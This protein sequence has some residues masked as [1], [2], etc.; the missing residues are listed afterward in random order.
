MKKVLAAI[1][2]LVMVLSML[3]AGMIVSS[4]LTS[5]DYTYTVANSEAT[6]T[7]YNGSGG[8]VTIPDSLGGTTVTTIDKSAFER[9][10]GLTNLTIPDSIKTIGNR[11]FGFCSNLTTVSIGIGVSAIGTYAF[12]HCPKL[13]QLTVKSAN[14][15]FYSEENVVFNKTKTILVVCAGGKEGNY[16]IPSTVNAIGESAFDSCTKLTAI[17]IPDGVTTIGIAAFSQ[18]SGLTVV[19]I[20]DS[21]TSI[22]TQAFILCTGIVNLDIGEGLTVINDS[23]FHACSNLV[24]LTI[25]SH[26]TDIGSGAFLGC[27]ALTVLELPNSLINIGSCSF[28][29]CD[30]LTE[31]TIPNNVTTVGYAAFYYCSELT[32]VTFGEHVAN[33]KGIAFAGC[34]KLVSACFTGNAPEL[35]N[36]VFID[37]PS[38]FIINY[39][40]G[41]TDFT[42][43]WYGYPTAIPGYSTIIFNTD[44]GTGGISSPM[45]PG[46]ALVAP[47]VTKAG[48][49]FTGWTPALPANV[50]YIHTTYT[51]LWSTYSVSFDAQGG[52]VSPATITVKNGSAY[53]ALPT[54]IKTGFVFLGWYTNPGGTGNKIISTT[55]VTITAPQTL[56]AYWIPVMTSTV[57]FDAQGGS[58]SPATKEVTSG[59]IYGTLPIPIKTDKTFGG[60]FTNVN[61]TG[62]NIYSTTMVTITS[63]QTLYAKW[64]DL[65]TC[66]VTFDAQGG[67]V[68]PVTREVNAG[69]MYGALP[70]PIRTGYVFYGWFTQPRGSGGNRINENQAV[71]SSHTVYAWWTPLTFSLTFDKHG[72]TG[73]ASGRTVTYG[74]PYGAMPVL[75]KADSEFG[76]WWT[77]PGGAGTQIVSTDQVSILNAQTLYAKWMPLSG[78]SIVFDAAGGTGGMSYAMNAGDTLTAP[79]AAKTGYTFKGWSPEVPAAAPAADTVYMAQWSINSY[80]ISFHAGFDGGTGYAEPVTQNYNTIVNLPATGFTRTGF[81]FIGWNTEPDAE[82]ALSIYNVPGHNE[83]LYA[84]Y[85]M[86]YYSL[87]LKLNNGTNSNFTS[88]SLPCDTWVNYDYYYFDPYDPWDPIAPWNPWDPWEPDPYDPDLYYITIEYPYYIPE[89][90]FGPCGTTESYGYTP[91]T[92]TGYKFVGWSESPTGTSTTSYTRMQTS[93]ITMYAVWEETY[94]FIRFDANGG[95]G[96]TSG[97]LQTCTALTP[98]IVTKPGYTF[99]GWW[100]EMPATVPERNTVYTAQW[101]VNSYFITFDANGGTGGT[102]DFMEYGEAITAPPVSRAGYIFTGWSQA[103]PATVGTEDATFTAQWNSI[104]DINNDGRISSVDAL[105][106]LQAA[107]EII[108]LTATQ[109]LVADVDINNTVSSVDALKILQFSTGQITSF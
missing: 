102:E 95:V 49:T 79:S 50:P 22:G 90:I 43:P 86:N 59:D 9:C 10:T 23:V 92:R 99:A 76:G 37:C 89:P 100:P 1:L 87:T 78:Y 31:V 103:V 98:P 41:K 3:P 65:N 101:Q 56:Y 28:Q 70:V 96:G 13:T 33:I 88:F 8:S 16:S 104:G 106:A 72:G 63:A 71:F 14:S 47:V 38:G 54:P 35:D 19:N 68:T 27:S 11:A 34:A 82:T 105:M 67:E 74:S 7:K 39:I 69:F 53:G 24:N 81:T 48:Y 80:T 45:L 20:P 26:V 2:A 40:S 94:S 77:S 6:I 25:G 21:V 58:V 84:V 30:G 15:S 60:W 44:G 42:S 93:D 62:I 97:L 36:D 12:G 107:S 73:S 32:K 75:T 4:A 46:T 17:A 64:N 108:T 18:C 55:S 57:T 109:L 83:T 52:S 85:S 51:A 29:S 91:P 5:G 66:L 61:G